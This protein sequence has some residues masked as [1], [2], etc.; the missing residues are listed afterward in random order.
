MR[1]TLIYTIHRKILTQ[2]TNIRYHQ[3]RWHSLNP[4]ANNNFL[5]LIIALAKS[6]VLHV[7]AV[8][9]KERS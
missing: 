4:V 3:I 8:L 2:L 1:D 6:S 9:K 7:N 5:C